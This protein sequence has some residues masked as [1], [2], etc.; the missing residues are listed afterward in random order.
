MSATD[1]VASDDDVREGAHGPCRCVSRST[2]DV[3]FRCGATWS[4]GALQVD[5]AV[6]LAVETVT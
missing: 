4:P 1:G 2:A 6:K 5:P 3:P